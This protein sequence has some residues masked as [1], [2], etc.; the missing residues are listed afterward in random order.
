MQ[1][2]ICSERTSKPVTQ[3]EDSYDCAR[4]TKAIQRRDD[5]GVDGSAFA[6][7]PNEPYLSVNCLDLFDDV[8]RESQLASLRAV[9]AQKMNVRPSALLSIINVGDTKARVGAHA[10]LKFRHE[11]EDDDYTH[12]GLYGTE[13]NDEIV[14]DLLAECVHTV[15]TASAR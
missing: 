3:I 10:S 9:L 1:R 14:Q 7:R 4:F 15:D 8:S 2:R 5:G 12:C 11:P 13:Y 6:L